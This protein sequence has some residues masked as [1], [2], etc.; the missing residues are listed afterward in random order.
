VEVYRTGATAILRD[1]KEAE[2]LSSGK[3]TTKK[4]IFQ[5]KGQAAM[6][7]RFLEAVKNGDKSPIPFEDISAVTLATFKAVESMHSGLVMPVYP[8]PQ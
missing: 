8:S 1:F 4:L 7:R 3:K 2:V 6:V 5:D